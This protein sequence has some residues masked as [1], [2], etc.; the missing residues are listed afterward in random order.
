VSDEANRDDVVKRVK[1]AFARVEGVAKVV[2]PNE[3]AEYG[4]GDSRRDP[5]APD[6]L[7]EAKL[8]YYFGDTA[9]GGKTEHKGSHGHDSHLPEL[10]AMFV[11]WGKGIKQGTKLGEIDNRSVAPTIAKLLGIEMPDVEG[12]ALVE[13]LAE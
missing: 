4:I 10:H 5:H 7:I 9:A 1:K 2:G 6:M 3:F 11:A 13:A 8:G 12:K